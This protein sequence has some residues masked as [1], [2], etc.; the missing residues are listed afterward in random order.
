MKRLILLL[1][2]LPILVTAQISDDFSDGDFT[3]NP[4]W[5]GATD[6]FKINSGFQLQLND[7]AAGTAY[8]ATTTFFTNNCEWRFWIKQSFSPSGNNYGRVYLMSNNQNLTEPLQGYFL[9]LGEPG[10][11]DAVEL[12][13][14]E[15][16]T[17]LS[18]CRGTDGLIAESFTLNIKVI[19]DETGNWE[20]FI[21]KAGNG[22]YISEASGTDNYWQ[23]EGY[24]GFLTNYT[25]SNS[26]KFYWDDVYVGEPY[27]DIDP[28]E[29][30]FVK[31]LSDSILIITFNEPVDENSTSVLTNY[32][33]DNNIGNPA[34]AASNGLNITLTFTNK[35][36]NGASYVLSVSNITDLAGNM[37]EPCSTEFSWYKAGAF[38][39]VF[40]EIYPDP[41]PSI[42]LP[43][44]EYLELYNRTNK[45]VSLDGWK[46]IVGTT[47]KKIENVTIQPNGYL[48]MGK[49][50]A[51]NDFANFGDFYGF[52]SFSLTNS[53]QTLILKNDQEMVIDQVSYT[54]NWYHDPEKE[55]GGWSIEQI[56][57]ENVCAG[58]DNWHASES[59]YGGTPGEKNS[60]FSDTLLYPD[61]NRFELIGNDVLR[62]WFNQSM[63]ATTIENKAF[64][65]V[66]NNV[67]QPAA[68]FTD[69]T[70]PQKAELYFSSPFSTGLFYT[71]QI[72][73]GITNCAGLH[74]VE[75]LTLSFGIPENI[76]PVEVV[77]NEIL[78]NP[79]NGGVDYV[80][81][82]NCSDKV[83]DLSGCKIG[84]VKISPPNPPD[85]M[86]YNI[87]GQQLLLI[88]QA[89]LVLT[90]SP[91]TIKQ[92]YYTENPDA[93]WQVSPFPA[94]NNE[95]GTAILSTLDDIIIDAFTYN[96]NMHYPLLQY[97]D[98][99]ALERI[100][101][102]ASTNDMNNWH[103]AAES[104]G[105][106]TP[107]YENS[108]WVNP[109]I[110]N[111]EI[112]ITP[113][114][115]S[116]DNDGHDDVI[117]ISYRFSEPCVNIKILIY[118]QNGRLIRHLT[119]N[120]LSGTSGSVNWD[121]ITD[122]NSKA[123]TGIYIFYIQSFDINGNVKSW[124]KTGV[125]ATKWE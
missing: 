73:T 114:L 33:V 91:E 13:R 42:G 113:E 120:E 5:S 112:T 82:Y 109:E 59:S 44:Y 108:Q 110:P 17:L 111:N 56:N 19:R 107:G 54:K 67:G 35:F 51:A 12:F 83:V 90:K 93:F 8:L 78:F 55:E 80:E 43:K 85:T 3:Q 52:S 18:V 29:I 30:E 71:L 34:H 48:I 66:D 37:M 25:K 95:S 46:L 77:I 16:E 89:Y 99:V 121:G 116:P 64:Y 62:I 50:E 7:T 122:D 104:V 88:P 60:V 72:S 74:P 76:E 61:V 57:P 4:P 9:Q 21:D 87:T 81:L 79:L 20:I 31:P 40:N 65:Q 1:L 96:E 103:S 63:D 36:Q 70:E 22:Q 23:T 45:P 97:T 28:P 32:Q 115:F 119:D 2:S 125:L 105:F 106:G 94:Y 100:N 27:V 10:G 123:M 14:Q 39:L 118:D 11:S 101:P 98:G 24:F 15:G 102:F 75:P 92:Q 124:K 41:S 38:D 68:V 26:T 47:E 84:T 49:E 117:T 6:K 69:P 53:G 86:Y 58:S